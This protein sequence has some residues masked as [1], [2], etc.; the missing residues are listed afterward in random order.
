MAKFKVKIID[1]LTKVV[2]VE[3]KSKEEAL[4]EV[5]LDYYDCT[6]MLN[7]DDDF[8]DVEFVIVGDQIEA[9]ANRALEHIDNLVTLAGDDVLVV[10][11]L[12]AL[13]RVLHEL[14]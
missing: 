9:E 6:H 13:T 12:E 7:H 3:A 5:E 10:A 8:F 2:E 1:T 14:K 11:E 4:D